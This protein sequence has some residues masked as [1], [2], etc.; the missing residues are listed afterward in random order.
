MRVVVFVTFIV[1]QINK[2][3]VEGVVLLKKVAVVSGMSGKILLLGSDVI[4]HLMA[5]IIVLVIVTE[6]NLV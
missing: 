1:Y 4:V 3:V 2:I 5:V 6:V